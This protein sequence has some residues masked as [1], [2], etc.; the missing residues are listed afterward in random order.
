[1]KCL[2]AVV[3]LAVLVAYC[4]A[5]QSDMPSSTSMPPTM[6]DSTQSSDAADTSSP[7]SSPSPTVTEKPDSVTPTSSASGINASALVMS[8]AVLFAALK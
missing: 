4:S 2:V 8:V 7:S 1:M 5:N 6:G 3:L